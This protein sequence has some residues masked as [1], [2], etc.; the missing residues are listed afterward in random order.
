MLFS[1]PHEDGSPFSQSTPQQDG[2]GGEGGP[3]LSNCSSRFH[4]FFSCSS[5]VSD[6]K[7]Q[8]TGFLGMRM[9]TRGDI[10]IA[11]VTPMAS[12]G[13]AS[14]RIATKA[15]KVVRKFAP[16]P[17]QRVRVTVTKTPE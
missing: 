11:T 6:E 2:F 12:A 8:S 16:L 3:T 13:R 17:F 7:Y 9:P 10:S 15:L 14:E 1:S 5:A 4:L